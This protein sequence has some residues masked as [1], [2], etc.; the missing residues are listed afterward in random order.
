MDNDLDWSLRPADELEQ[1]Q[2][3]EENG[4]SWVERDGTK[5]WIRQASSPNANANANHAEGQSTDDD[6]VYLEDGTM[7]DHPEEEED[8]PR[9][10][11][12]PTA[13]AAAAAADDEYH[14]EPAPSV[15]ELSV[16]DQSEEQA[17]TEDIY[18][19]MTTV[20]VSCCSC[21]CT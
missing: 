20:G 21:Y 2:A 6:A 5:Q 1:A 14:N 11:S 8:R 12:S 7:R 13:A 19:L 17:L 10:Y 9:E 18:S 4:L 15:T 3:A 16:N